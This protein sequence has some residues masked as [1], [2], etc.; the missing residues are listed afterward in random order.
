MCDEGFNNFA[1]LLVCSRGVVSTSCINSSVYMCKL[2]LIHCYAPKGQS[3]RSVAFVSSPV[4]L[5][6]HILTPLDIQ[7]FLACIL[8]KSF[9]ILHVW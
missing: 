1:L 4:F 2:V 7:L 6:Y 3:L 8:C 9:I 5:S